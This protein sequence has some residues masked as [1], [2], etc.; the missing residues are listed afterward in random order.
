MYK[1]QTDLV[2]VEREYDIT[3]T[4]FAKW[5]DKINGQITIQ[6]NSEEDIEDWRLEFLSDVDFDNVWNAELL[7]CADGY[8]YLENMSYNQNIPAGGSVSFGF[9]ATCEKTPDFSEH[10]L[11]EIGEVQK[12]SADGDEEEE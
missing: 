7:E 1:R 5:D 2:E 9:I 6:N 8:S 3:Y 11:Y 12:D 4:E 10:I